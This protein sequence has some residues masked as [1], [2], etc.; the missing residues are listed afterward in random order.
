MD[1]EE[2]LLGYLKR[3]TAELRET[4]RRLRAVERRDAEPIAIVAMA[5]RYPGGVS[6]PEDLWR[7]VDAGRDAIT[8]FPTD[9]GWDTD[10]VYD[11]RPGVPGK[12]YSREGGFLDDVAGFDPDFFGI[13]PREALATDPQQRLLLEVA[14]EALERGGLD[15]AALR[16]SRTGVF[17][18]VMYRDYASKL[19]RVPEEVEG[20]LGTGGLGSVVSGRVAYTFGFEGPAVTVDTACSSS[21]VALH[22]AVRALRAG[23]CDLA[24][25]GGVT[26]MSTP[27]TFIDFSR[28]RGLAADGR[29]KSF[30]DDADGTGWGEGAGVLLVE[31]LSDAERLGHPVLAVVRGSAVNSDGASSGLTAPNG[32]SQQRVIRDALA[33]AGLIA[34][35]VDLVEAHGTGTTLGDPIEA[36]ALL[37]TYGQGRDEPLWLGSVKSNIGHTQ[38]AAGVAGIIKSVLAMRHGVLPRTLHVGEPSSRVDWSAGAVSLLAEA[39][40]WPSVDRPR[41]A[42]VSSF[43]ISGT[44]A[45]VILEGVTPAEE[46]P[47][48]SGAVV[49]WVLSGRTRAAVSAQAARLGAVSGDPVDV[50][51]SLATSRSAFP[52]RAVVV[53]SSAED[54]AAGLDA[55]AAGAPGVARGEVVEGGVAFLFTGQGAQRA[56]MGLTAYQRFP[57]YAAAFDEVAAALAPWLDRPLAEV[58]ASADI[59]RTEYAQ[60]ALFA[61]E[62]ALFRLVVSWG[63]R[64][65]FLAGHSIGEIAA[66]HVAGVLS[67]DDAARLVAARGRLMQALPEGGAMVALPVPEDDV[68]PLLSDWVDLAAVNGPRSVVVSGDEDEVL[69]VAA[70]FGDQGKRL[71]VSHAFHSHRMNA[72]LGEFRTVAESLTYSPPTIPIVSTAGGFLSD[73]SGSVNN[74]VPLGGDPSAGTRESTSGGT[75][76]GT[77]PR[78]GAAGGVDFGAEY[79]VRHARVAVRF[80]DAVRQLQADGVRTFL[81]LGPHGVL[82]AM[83]QEFLDDPAAVVPVLVRDRPDDVALVEALARL[84]V[85]GARVDWEAFF[86]PRGARRVDLP[87]YPF[88]RERYWLDQAAPVGDA[89]GLGQTALDHPLLGAAVPDPET[90]GVVCTGLLSV[91]THPWLADH[92]VLGTILV[93]G[94]GLVE[95]VGRAAAEVGCETVE[96]LT[97][98]APLVLPEQGAV[99]VQVTVGAPDGDG[100][101]PVSVHSRPDEDDAPWTKHATGLLTRTAG[102]PATAEAWPPAGAEPLPL[103]GLY[104]RLADQ[105]YVY[106]PAFR[107]LR[108]AWRRG[109]EVFAEAALPDAV[110][111]ADRYGLHPALFDAALHANLIEESAQGTALPFAWHGVTRRKHG[112]RVVR[113]RIS[114]TADGLAVS[115]SDEAGNPVAEVRSLV[116]RPVSA[117]QLGGARPRS[118]YRVEWTPFALP[119]TEPSDGF[120]VVEPELRTGGDV[121]AAVRANVDTTLRLI[122]DWLADERQAHAKLVVVTRTADLAV[123]PIRGLVRSAQAEHADRFVLADLDDD[124]ASTR[125]LPAALASGEPEITVRGGKASAPRLVRT[126]PAGEPPKFTG[127]VLVTGGTTGLG[128]LVARHLVVEHGV[129]DL[130]LVSRRGHAP[131]P[132]ADLRALGADV[133]VAACDV[134]DRDALAALL[135]EHP[136]KAVVHAAGVVDNAVITALT[137]EQVD[138]VLRPKVDAAWNLH[139]LTGD[140]DAFVL[141]SSAAG[142]VVGAGQ[143]NYAAANVFLDALAEHRRAHGLPATSLAWGL[144]DGTAGLAAGLD[145]AGFARMRRLGMPP[146]SPAEGLDL[147]DAALA[148]DDAVLVPI[149]LDQAALRARTDALPGMLRDLG[150]ATEAAA[151]VDLPARLRDLPPAERER[152]LLDLVRGTVAG[153]LGHRGAEAVAPDRAFSELGFDSLAAVELRNQ[154]NQATGLRLPSTLVFDYPS[155]AVLAGHLDVLLTPAEADPTAAVLAEVDRLAAVIAAL[156]PEVDRGPVTARLDALVRRWHDTHV[157]AAGP[158]EEPDFDAAT[159]EELFD[160][161]DSELGVDTAR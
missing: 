95:L 99:A 55:V 141:F 100:F 155:A 63:V 105:G 91:R 87:T 160:A 82:T 129:R 115:L 22:L 103:D 161:L 21:L 147:F 47:V 78:G 36:Q 73:L 50:A 121:P 89:G 45:H 74:R 152:A 65:D 101:R 86:A 104:D 98:A 69:R 38:A 3:T 136:V 145:D 72:A 6:S 83:A 156:D 64:P 62:V 94:T 49:P 58:L 25:A 114:P 125:A 11:P 124:P 46:P 66:A 142:L 13:S 41:R 71:R 158:D 59:D 108:A 70:A 67:L 110:A 39:R 159:D 106:G 35:D 28:Q 23:E 79:W 76:A 26:V 118:L 2:K 42:A 150:R 131:E 40:P 132:A 109:D 128:A 56:G 157:S 57:A 37:A 96:E 9:R 143:G 53:G 113:T 19:T 32:P 24:L 14:W 77:G 17:A 60:P 75:S 137:P 123:A 61:V 119:A 30:S 43:G 111:D 88:Q 102:H 16:G 52:H 18:G 151:P 122:R 149:R 80:H 4:K 84:H 90:G 112:V 15:P 148:A 126:N 81:E 34:A 1:N 20:Y 10:G 92:E 107:A 5:C 93:P 135:A 48:P 154:L 116:A 140:L 54:F 127:T 130:L 146:L 134:A 153:V 144:W 7:L 44:N 33:N 8:E 133:T 117:A 12:T 138:R 139:E 85:R 31:R 27:A 29:C 51:Y 120:V 68:L 97:L